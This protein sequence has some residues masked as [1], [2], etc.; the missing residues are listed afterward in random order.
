[1]TTQNNMKAVALRTFG[2]PE[3]LKL[4]A[5]PMPVTADDQIVIRVHFAGVGKWDV[6]EREGLFAEMTPGEPTFPYILGS[7]GAGTVVKTGKN[8]TQFNVG[9]SVYGIVPARN[10]KAGFYA[11]YVAVNSNKAWPIPRNLT[12]QQAAALALDGGTA[13]RGL[14][15]SLQVGKDDTVMIVGASGGIGHMAIQ[16][17]K[18]LGARVFA[19]A[20]GN[21]GVKLALSLG[22]DTALDGKTVDVVAAAAVFAPKGI[23]TALITT[24]SPGVAKMLQAVRKDG[25]IAYPYG[26]RLN[27]DKRL[28]GY[29]AD[30]DEA[31]MSQLNHIAADNF[32]VHIDQ[33]FSLANV[34]AAH[35]SLGRHHI[36]R[37]VLSVGNLVNT[38]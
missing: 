27:P 26:V 20:S 11:E 17:A 32:I 12:V 38:S 4:Q 21:D 9:E 33:V 22:A 24:D 6:L 25:R 5:V 19:V 36:G 28:M 1:M 37:V 29:N 15:D 7:E 31:L 35:R 16:I 2:G 10:P 14:K 8:V 13:L 34:S 30:Y 3:A 23:D 18:R